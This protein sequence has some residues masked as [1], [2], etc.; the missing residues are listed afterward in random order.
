MHKNSLSLAVM[1]FLY[2]NNKYELCHIT[3]LY[4]NLLLDGWQEVSHNAKVEIYDK[5]S[6]ST[7]TDTA[8]RKSVCKLKR[9]ATAW[10]KN[11]VISWK[12]WQRFHM[13][14]CQF[15]QNCVPLPPNLN[16]SRI[17]SFALQT[18]LCLLKFL[19]WI[20]LKISIC[21]EFYFSLKLWFEPIFALYWDP[22]TV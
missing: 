3:T 1:I 6:S 18:D 22:P 2:N 19:L 17:S 12:L 5:S 8:K 13:A 10:N 20:V 14:K 21:L 7:H 16:L 9:Y 4:A 11:F 15:K